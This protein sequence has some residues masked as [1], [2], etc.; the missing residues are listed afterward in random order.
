MSPSTTAPA[1][2][3]NSLW[4][5]LAALWL[6]ILCWIPGPHPFNAPGWA[7]TLIRSGTGVSAPLAGIFAT[8]I[9][10]G[11]GFATLGILLVPCLKNCKKNWQRLLAF[12]TAFAGGL[13]A[14]RVN[15]GYCPIP[16]QIGMVLLSS[17]FGVLCGIALTGRPK[18]LPVIGI[19][20]LSLFLWAANTSVDDE[21]FEI[22]R[23][24]GLHILQHAE[25]IPDGDVGFLKILELAFSCGE[26]LPGDD[27]VLENK[28]LLLALSAIL[29]EEKVAR[30]ARRDLQLSHISQA[31]ALRSRITL[32]DRPDLPQHFWV[33][34][35]LAVLSQE[36]T[37]WSAGIT[38]EVK[39]ADGGSG[40]SFVDLTADRAGILFSRSAT[41]SRKSAETVQQH[42][43]QGVTTADIC[44]D[45]RDLPE[46]I[47][48]EEFQTVYG[49]LG[50]RKTREYSD[51]I[52]KR[53]SQCALLQ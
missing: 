10:R 20:L 5:V 39:D 46:G 11:L 29:G 44:P 47:P 41:H 6:A 53:L 19:Y 35:G 7:V 14:I 50:G 30:I 16:Q 40:F 18:V 38:K 51:V 13:M 28:G 3:L 31:K 37:S 4:P 17:V 26:S 23:A 33:S 36:Q 24:A 27:P 43:R 22:T 25:E 8:F 32:Y 52:R 2:N 9:L 42:I 49:G 1:R 34:A 48:L 12:P 15:A 45:P 21:L